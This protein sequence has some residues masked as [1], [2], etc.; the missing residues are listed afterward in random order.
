MRRT[1]NPKA[2]SAARKSANNNDGAH[3]RLAPTTRRGPTVAQIQRETVPIFPISIQRTDQLYYEKQ[4]ELTGTAGILARYVFS[5]NGAYD[6]NI[7]GTGHQPSGW[8]TMMALYEQGVVTRSRIKVNFRSGINTDQRVAIVLTPDANTFSSIE[9]LMENGLLVTD[10]V[11]GAG[12]VGAYH[13][14]KTL[15]LDCDVAKYFGRSRQ[16]L[17]ASPEYY[18]TAASNP[19]EQV[20]YQ[21]CTWNPSLASNTDVLLDVVLSYDIYYY[22][23]RKLD[24]SLLAASM[25]PSKKAPLSLS[26]SSSTLSFKR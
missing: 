2:R 11:T 18:C 8:D 10:V 9:A 26:S 22:E 6:P 24:V 1:W 19:T 12:G 20:Y 5:A 7:T 4:I 23:P 15:E 16:E 17:I 3:R 13:T 21:I 25:Q 14:Q